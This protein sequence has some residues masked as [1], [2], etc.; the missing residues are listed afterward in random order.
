MTPRG[1]PVAEVDVEEACERVRC[2]WWW[3]S[4][5]P[6]S[7]SVRR[8]AGA[9]CV[10][11]QIAYD[12]A[13]VAAGQ[14]VR[15]DR[16]VLGHR[17]LR[18]RRPPPGRG[19]PR[20]A[21]DAASRSSCSRTASDPWSLGATPMP[22]TASS[23]TC[24]STARCTPGTV[25]IAARADDPRPRFAFGP[26]IPVAE[27]ATAGAPTPAPTVT[28]ADSSRPSAP[29]GATIDGTT[30]RRWLVGAGRARGGDRRRPRLV[31]PSSRPGSPGADR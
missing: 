13:P 11:P 16:G 2:S 21:P 7:P 5:W 28:F 24:R 6:R 22:T 1:N 12:V 18:H 3:A 20:G 19:R 27:V 14:V 29:S 31:G 26:E 23:S 9:S 25:T 30:D 4:S 10:G 15:V 17:L 8:V